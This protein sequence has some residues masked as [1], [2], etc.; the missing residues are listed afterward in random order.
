MN[1]ESA[2]RRAPG[3]LPLTGHREEDRADGLPVLQHQEPGDWAGSE[4]QLP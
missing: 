4:K 3:I 1:K 2:S